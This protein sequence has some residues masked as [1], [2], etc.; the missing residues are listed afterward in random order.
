MIRRP[1]QDGHQH[2]RERLGRVHSDICGPMDVVSLG[3]NCYFCLLVDDQSGYIWYHPV[4][5]KLDFSEWFVRMDKLFLNQFG[6][7]VKIVRMTNSVYT[8]FRY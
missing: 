8:Q 5:N 2:M 1:F 6:T 4:S 3:G 7:H